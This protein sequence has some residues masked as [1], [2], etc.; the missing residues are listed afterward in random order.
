MRNCSGIS[1][2]LRILSRA[3]AY[4]SLGYEL[5]NMITCWETFL[6]RLCQHSQS[7]KTHS[8]SKVINYS[9][10]SLATV[11]VMQCHAQPENYK[12]KISKLAMHDV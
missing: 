4:V 12:W 5:I 10:D 9:V 11:S 6:F 1:I 3:C 8:G 2:S 7:I